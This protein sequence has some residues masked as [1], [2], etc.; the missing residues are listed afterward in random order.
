MSGAL[1]RNP[2]SGS[3]PSFRLKEW[4]A[5]PAAS[6]PVQIEGSRKNMA[7]SYA[8]QGALTVGETKYLAT[9]RYSAAEVAFEQDIRNVTA[10]FRNGVTNVPAQ[11]W[12]LAAQAL[13]RTA[14]ISTHPPKWTI[15]VADAVAKLND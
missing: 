7:G 2:I 5:R 1:Q 13:S 10:D 6:S 12:A 11:T 4:T 9:I 15:D 3:D 8:R 14:P